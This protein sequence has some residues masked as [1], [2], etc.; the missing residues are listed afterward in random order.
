MRAREECADERRYWRGDDD[1]DECLNFLSPAV[2]A[3]WLCLFCT[4]FSKC[5]GCASRAPGGGT[6]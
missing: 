3:Q 4:R 6:F 1:D 5:Y 2:L